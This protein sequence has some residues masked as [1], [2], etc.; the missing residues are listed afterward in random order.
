IGWKGSCDNTPGAYLTGFLAGT[1]SI[2]AGVKEAVL[3][4]GRH[5]PVKG[6]VIFAALKGMLDAGMTLPHSKEVLPNN[7]RVSGKH[8]S[9]SVQKNFTSVKEKMKKGGDK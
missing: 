2:E 1:R 8:L 3:D 6:S 4:I 7:D 5:A 9:E